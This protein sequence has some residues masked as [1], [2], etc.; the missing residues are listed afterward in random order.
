MI[1]WNSFHHSQINV[2]LYNDYSA[3]VGV[4]EWRGLVSIIFNKERSNL[5]WNGQAWHP[6][7]EQIHQ[8]KP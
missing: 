4:V 1:V 3:I 6:E 8:Q 5:E 7:P 2:I